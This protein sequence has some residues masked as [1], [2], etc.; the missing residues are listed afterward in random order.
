MVEKRRT[1][2][3]SSLYSRITI[4][5]WRDGSVETVEDAVIREARIGLWVNGDLLAHL[6]C[7]P[8]ELDALAVGFLVSEGI[9]ARAEDLESVEV[10][11]EGGQ[12]HCRA[13]VD[14]EALAARRD[15]WTLGTGCGGG[16]TGT[17]PVEPSKCRRI[18]TTT[19]FDARV[20]AA[21]GVDFNRSSTL[22]AKTGG[23]H[24]AALYD[25]GGNL[26]A[27]ADDIG[28]HNAFDKL[29]GKALLTGIDV[30]DKALLTTGRISADIAS[31]A[32]RHK[33]Q[34]IASRSAPTTRALWLAQRYGISVVGFLRGRRM[35]VYTCPERITGPEEGL[36]P[37]EPPAAGELLDR[38]R[39]ATAGGKLPCETAH[40]ISREMGV[41]LAEV[42]AACESAG[43]KIGECQLGCF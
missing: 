25:T 1:E 40:L 3:D 14:T 36:P 34:L 37:S 11:T 22:Y 39:H 17:D 30:G 13:H 5:R 16:G 20:L 42:G 29:V 24:S 8:D 33:I 43:I 35:N 27:R 28:R 12:V 6:M 32:I 4:K 7:L 9:L 26:I 10:D 15:N 31:K 38:I 21:A 23:V 19:R 41:A 18:D 2:A